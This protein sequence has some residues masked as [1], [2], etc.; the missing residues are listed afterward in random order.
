[1]TRRRSG[2]PSIRGVSGII[3]GGLLVS[4]RAAL[5]KKKIKISRKNGKIPS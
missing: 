4:S 3:L 1:L 2:S 5:K